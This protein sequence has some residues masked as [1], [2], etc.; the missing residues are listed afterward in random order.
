M[1][2]FCHVKISETYLVRVIQGYSTRITI[3]TMNSSTSAAHQLNSSSQKAFPNLANPYSPL[4]RPDYQLSLKLSI[5][6][7]RERLY[8]SETLLKTWHFGCVYGSL[9]KL[10]PELIWAATGR[11]NR[12]LSSFW[13]WSTS[14]GTKGTSLTLRYICIFIPTSEPPKW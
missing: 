1:A 14:K 9:C 3:S 5:T 13:I 6:S 7:P 8:C 12:P 4:R 10:C 2:L 11:H